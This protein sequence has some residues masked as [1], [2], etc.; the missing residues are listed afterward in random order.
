MKAIRE[1][2]SSDRSVQVHPA[3]LRIQT[4]SGHTFSTIEKPYLI[5]VFSSLVIRTNSLLCQGDCL[6]SA[7]CQVYLDIR[8]YHKYFIS[9]VDSST[10]LK[11]LQILRDRLT[12]VTPISFPIPSISQTSMLKNTTALRALQA[13]QKTGPHRSPSMSILSSSLVP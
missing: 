10:Q 1:R 7:Q 3:P 12:W 11:L 4:L 5:L 8:E 9:N 6:V 13:T 2:K